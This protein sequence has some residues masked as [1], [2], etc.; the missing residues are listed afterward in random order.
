MVEG[1]I[2]IE[3]INSKEERLSMAEE[4]DYEQDTIDSNEETY[5]DFPEQLSITIEN[6]FSLGLW[7]GV[8]WFFSS[9]VIALILIVIFSVLGISVTSLALS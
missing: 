8:G 5:I 7:F 3:F 1:T 4:D 6:P 9:F 2:D